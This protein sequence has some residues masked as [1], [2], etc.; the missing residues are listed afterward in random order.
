L[1]D[2][3]DSQD[4]G[5]ARRDEVKV[6][7]ETQIRESFASLETECRLGVSD[8]AAWPGGPLR[9]QLYSSCVLGLLRNDPTAVRALV[10]MAIPL[11]TDFQKG[12]AEEMD[13]SLRK[14]WA[15][16]AKVSRRLKTITQAVGHIKS[17]ITVT[18]LCTIAAGLS[19]LILHLPTSVHLRSGFWTGLNLQIFLGCF[20]AV[21]R[22]FLK[23]STFS[24]L[25]ERWVTIAQE[26]RILS[27]SK[28]S[29]DADEIVARHSQQIVGALLDTCR[30]KPGVFREILETH[31]KSFWADAALSS[32]SPLD[33]R[34]IRELLVCLRGPQLDAADKFR[35][36]QR[37]AVS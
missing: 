10:S 17:T 3:I 21:A 18:L 32:N 24:R 37:L 5:S 11:S 30:S 13:S 33:L 19:I 12:F 6:L 1:A 27:P 22:T 20:L 35:L 8:S 23:G 4:F 36:L 7:P 31:P 14:N 25:L 28:P 29:A 9:S 16:I 26:D 15:L 34:V 2:T